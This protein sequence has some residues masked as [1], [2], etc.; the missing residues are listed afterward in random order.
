MGVYMLDLLREICKPVLILD[1]TAHGKMESLSEYGL[2]LFLAGLSYLNVKNTEQ[3]PHHP[4]CTQA[5]CTYGIF[6]TKIEFNK[7]IGLQIFQYFVLGLTNF[8][9]DMFT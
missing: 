6:G 8:C 4:P 2:R 7:E 5:Q 3:V 1:F 9:S